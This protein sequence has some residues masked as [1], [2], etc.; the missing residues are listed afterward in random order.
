MKEKTEIR[1]TDLSTRHV[2]SLKTTG[3]TNKMQ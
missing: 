2:L 3:T 1:K